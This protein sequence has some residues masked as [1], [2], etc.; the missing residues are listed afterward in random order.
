MNKIL[1]VIVYI[2]MFFC[3]AECVFGLYSIINTSN[4]SFISMMAMFITFFLFACVFIFLFRFS[5]RK[6]YFNKKEKANKIIEADQV[7]VVEE[8]TVILQAPEEQNIKE[9]QQ[10]EVEEEPQEKVEIVEEKQEINEIKNF[11]EPTNDDIQKLTE[12]KQQINDVLEQI[13]VLSEQVV[14]AQEKLKYKTIEKQEKK[15]PLDDEYL[16]TVLND[17]KTIKQ[18]MKKDLLKI[19]KEYYSNDKKEKVS[20][21]N[22]KYNE[23]FKINENE[24][25]FFQL[26]EEKSKYKLHF[27]RLSN[28]TFNV[29]SDDY[30][31][32]GKLHLR[33]HNMYATYFIGDKDEIYKM[34]GDVYNIAK[35]INKWNEY[36][37]L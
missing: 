11:E 17:G 32:L 6:G 10:T 19:K 34:E 27:D 22:S 25:M 1:K 30:T 37:D 35:C 4:K 18:H 21:V 2:L 16:N 36:I 26:V 3:L 9:I 28:G 23:K 8:D 31:F 15:F 13:K 14:D 7:E 29:R 5:K 12:Q 24:E 20:I 33:G